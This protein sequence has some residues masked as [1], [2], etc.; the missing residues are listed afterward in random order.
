MAL[1]KLEKLTKIYGGLVAVD[2]VNF[3]IYDGQ[4]K[5]LIGPNGAGKTTIFNLITGVDNA[6]SGS[7]AFKDKSLKRLKPY[8]IA[9]LGISRTFQNIQLF[10]DMTVL[11]N[12]MV[13]RHPR[14]KGNLIA[15]A[16]RLPIVAREESAI[17][18]DAVEMVKF[19][20]LLERANTYA[21]NLSHGER[22]L[23]EIARALATEPELLL[24]DE[25]AAGLNDQGTEELM[26]LIYKIRDKGI[27]VFL[28]EH[29]MGLVMEVS[30]EVVVL[31]HG[32]KIA[33]GPPL[34]IQE[35]E[36]VIEAYLGREI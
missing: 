15:S 31:D 2:G 7:I 36:Q 30:D 27:T 13:G 23:L 16:L 10:G 18:E 3:T 28:V 35:D 17:F 32:R 34:L 29:N 4:I 20:G 21:K 9:S 5:A 26:D 6:D 1:L 19:T 25:P 22:R 24:L 33:E 12:V 14:T 8:Q 11:E